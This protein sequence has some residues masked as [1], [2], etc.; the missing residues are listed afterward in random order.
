M[1]HTL[2]RLPHTRSSFVTHHPHTALTTLMHT[3]TRC[4]P[5]DPH[6]PHPPGDLLR[7]YRQIPIHFVLFGTHGSIRFGP[8]RFHVRMMS[9]WTDVDRVHGNMCR[10]DGFFWLAHSLIILLAICL[11]LH[12]CGW[13]RSEAVADWGPG[14]CISVKQNSLG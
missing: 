7:S 6:S 3:P 9:A 8:P 1:Y 11:C 5:T 13:E 14:M 12:S 2:P 10:V 4:N